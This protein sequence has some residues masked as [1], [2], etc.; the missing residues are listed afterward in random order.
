[1]KAGAQIVSCVG[2]G[3]SA[4][5]VTGFERSLWLGASAIVTLDADGAH[6]P[7]DIPGLL[8]AHADARADLSIGDRFSNADTF[9]PSSK[10]WVN[11]LGAALFNRLFGT[12]LKDIACGLR[13]YSPALA[14][15]LTEAADKTGFGLA[16]DSLVLVNAAGGVIA[17]APVAVRYDATRPLLTAGGE[18]ADGLRALLR[19]WDLH[20]RRTANEVSGVVRSLLQCVEAQRS[21]SVSFDKYTICGQAY[22]AEGYYFHVQ[23]PTLSGRRFAPAFE[24]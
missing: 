8:H 12:E 6:L 16:I 20:P 14:T 23:H 17:S 11:V 10:R 3:Y 1:M 18:L 4:A 13:V 5:I 21:F 7:S 19:G 22:G 9:L 15:R 24:L 2:T